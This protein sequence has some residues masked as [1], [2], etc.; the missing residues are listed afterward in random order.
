MNIQ[1]LKKIILS[2]TQDIEFDFNG[3]HCSICPINAKRIILCYNGISKTYKSI[4]EAMSST[5]FDGKSLSDICEQVEFY[6]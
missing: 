3:I 2:F 6:L 1:K 5:L 4:D